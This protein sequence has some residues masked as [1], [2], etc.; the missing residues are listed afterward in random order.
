[1]KVNEI[2]IRKATEKDTP[3]ICSLIK[4]IAEYEKLSQEVQTT[5]EKM[6]ETLYGSKSKAESIITY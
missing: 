5:N 4:E 6:K 3:I 2:R 1:M